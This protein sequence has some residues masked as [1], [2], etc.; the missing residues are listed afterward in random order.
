VKIANHF[1]SDLKINSYLTTEEIE[2]T[3]EEKHKTLVIPA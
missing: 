3:E 2:N 1:P